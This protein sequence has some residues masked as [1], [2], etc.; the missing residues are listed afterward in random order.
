V[1]RDEHNSN[2]FVVYANCYSPFLSSNYSSTAS[3]RF[4]VY[5]QFWCTIEMKL[6]HLVRGYN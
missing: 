2:A 3:K 4:F 6:S 1:A 5:L